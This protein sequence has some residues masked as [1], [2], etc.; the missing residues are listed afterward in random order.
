MKRDLS[1]P[2]DGAT[3]RQLRVG[4]ILFLTG[5]IFTARDEAHLLML[6]AQESG[7]DIPFDPSQMALF[8]C[9]PVVSKQ[10]GGW[11]VIAAGPTTSIRM[12]L[13]E[14]KYLET[15]RP[16][17]IIGKGGMGDRTQ[18]ALESVGA[19]Y[20][21][22]TG[23]A[24][25]LAAERIESIEGVEWLEELGMPEAAWFFKVK[26]FGPL[27]VTMDSVGGNL[28]KDL[29][30]TIAENMKAVMARIEAG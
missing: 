15:F 1:L 29:E 6:E 26:D 14:D 11:K 8:H 5:S 4:D 12:E 13:F 3:A 21:H 18:A 17:I 20:T 16:P 19:V 2:I 25:A 22:Y 30:P 24:G 23:G 27:L 28:Y 10:N 9:G 7:K